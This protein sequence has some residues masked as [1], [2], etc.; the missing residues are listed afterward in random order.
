MTDSVY[1]DNPSD[2][3]AS[4]TTTLDPPALRGPA[5][6]DLEG[7][8]GR[9]PSLDPAQESLA[10]AL[11]LTFRIVQGVMLLLA[12]AFLI[13]GVQTVGESERG[14]K[15]V[16]G[17]VTQ[18]EVQPG[19]RWNWPYPFG[20][21]VRVG[22]SQESV[23]IGD[24]FMPKLH[25]SQRAKRWTEIQTPKNQ[26]KPGEDGSIV[27]AD[28][29]IAHLECAVT[30]HRDDPVANAQNVYSL[31]EARLIRASTQRGIV[32][33]AA[34]TPIDGL[35]RQSSTSSV[36]GS[37]AT[38]VR[39]AAQ[40]ILD[41]VGSGI[42]I[43]T[44]TVRD[45]RPPL[46]VAKQFDAVARA[47]TEAAKL[48]ED[49][50]RAARLTLTD[51]AGAAAEPLLERI[52]AYER[53]LEMGSD[54][55]REPD[56]IMAQIDALLDGAPVT[57]DGAAV[58][59]TPGGQVTRILNDARQYRTDVVT[60]ARSRAEV[61][62]AKLAQFRVDP[63]VLVASDW[64]DAY[65]AFLK[66]HYETIV[67]PPHTNGELV[68]TPDPEIPRK[69]ER[70]RNRRQAD[71]TIQERI[72]YLQNVF[73]VREDERKAREARERKQSPSGGSSG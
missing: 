24:A 62:E 7:D 5:M 59:I 44:V 31:D 52:D 26:L 15:L 28:G 67:T 60:R 69:M 14:I 32:L 43:D 3:A 18:A 42:I 73:N 50:N 38:Q 72:D 10:S 46:A 30:F 49:A 64:A 6:L 70:E 56:S 21:I 39:R 61:F 53:A 2:A 71:M 48:R 20:E 9:G 57:I 22:T 33:A 1:A 27:T 36:M 41:R 55:E 29:A 68:L 4:A 23:N 34:R 65:Q 66:D 35:L 13:S 16:F 11:R 19:I 25:P 12:A 47:E 40:E 17:A 45:P 54:A 51:M 8:R 63:A 37:F 58:E